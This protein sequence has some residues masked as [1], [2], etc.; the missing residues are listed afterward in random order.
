MNWCK[1]RIE[2]ALICYHCS[3]DG[4]EEEW[5][6]CYEFDG[7]PDNSAWTSIQTD[8]RLE[9]SPSINVENKMMLLIIQRFKI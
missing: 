8:G 7:T 1:G 4:C 2:L 3:N 9:T 6:N 5:D